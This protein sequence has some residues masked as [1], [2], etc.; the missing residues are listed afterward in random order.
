MSEPSAWERFEQ[1]QRAIG[2]GAAG[3]GLSEVVRDL[4][5]DVPTIE[6]PN[7]YPM[8]WHGDP[9]GKLAQL[10]ERAKREVWNPA[11]LPWDQLDPA[12]F[13]RE[14]RL[15]VMYWYAVLANF[16][17]SGPPVFA[18]AM[19]HSYEQ[20]E[21]DEVR[22][23]FFSITR[24][25]VNH[26][27]VCQRT[28]GRLWS[29]TPTEW[30]PKGELEALALRNIRWLY[31]NGGRYWKGYSEALNKYPMPVLFS[32]F[33]MGEVAATTLFHTMSRQARHPVFAQ[34]LRNVGK[35]EAR[36]MAICLA[37][38]EQSFPSLTPEDKAL[39]TKQ[40]RAGFVFL[41]MILYEPPDEFWK[42]PPEFL[43]VHRELEEIA[44]RA[45]LG[46]ATLDVKREVW[47]QA[48]FKVKAV[49]ERYGIEFPAMP[50]V[51]ITGREV[52][53]IA[54]EDIIPVF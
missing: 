53:D 44:R 14:Q 48:M 54:F 35:D 47:R 32:S 46:V 36:H 29:V 33:M 49:V 1:E 25:E 41:S 45:G 22:K 13:T 19:I 4:L 6:Q 11:D 52:V 37:T 2:G 8:E 31:Y 5:A 7:I 51:G 10:Y 38:L 17:G 23:A 16:D 30:E 28:V 15:A 43:S 18:K 21:P 34:G 27:E 39:I 9:H 20:H 42:L 40:L 26:E 50:E 12:D 24:D 3:D